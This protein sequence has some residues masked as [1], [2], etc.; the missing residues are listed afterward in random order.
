MGALFV[1]DHLGHKNTQN[2][3]I[4]AQ[5]TNHLREDVFRELE[6]HPTIGRLHTQDRR[7]ACGR[8]CVLTRGLSPFLSAGV[9][10]PAVPLRRGNQ[11]TEKA[12]QAR[13]RSGSA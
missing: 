3:R 12:A 10:E 7:D 8:P 6:Q 2:T 11:R 5:I 4:D 1:A 9:A 13:Y